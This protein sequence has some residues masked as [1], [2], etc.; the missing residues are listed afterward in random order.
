[1]IGE[2]ALSRF[3]TNDTCEQL[4]ASLDVLV[5][6]ADEVFQAEEDERIAIAID[7]MLSK[8]LALSR[9]RAFLEER[10][11]SKRAYRTNWKH[12][13]RSLYFRIDGS[14]ARQAR[15]DVEALQAAFV[16]R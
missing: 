13:L 8:G 7:A 14:E 11:L 2:C 10:D 12:I 4:L 1:M 16:V 3:S 15:R 6:R 5:S 9:L